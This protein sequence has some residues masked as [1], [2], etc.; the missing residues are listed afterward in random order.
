VDL[1]QLEVFCSV[2]KE[3][4]FSRAAE[5]L[6]LTQPTISIRIKEFEESIGTSLFNRLGREIEPTDAG[7]FLYEQALPLLAQRRQLSAKLTSFLNRVE[8]PVA[9]GTSSALG[10]HQLP[11]L[12][13]AFQVDHPGVRVKL[14]FFSNSER[15]LEE[16]RNGDIDLGV[17]V[18]TTVGDDVV[19]EPFSTEELVLITPATGDW[20]HRSRIP[21][22]ELKGLPLIVLD[23]GSATRTSLEQALSATETRLVDMNVVA[24]MGRTGAIKE[25]VK[26]GYGVAFVSRSAVISELEA[27]TLRTA[28]VPEIGPIRR[29]FDIVYGRRRQLSPTA[30]ACLEHLR[31]STPLTDSDIKQR[32][33]KPPQRKSTA[34]R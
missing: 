6:G 22:S 18:A 33:V 19:A 10:E 23:T 9:V 2:F 24:E 31:R 1:I 7:K 27:G 17:V 4:S 21:L 32:G 12:M 28:D 15:T 25:A 34:R 30:T 20:R 8:G 11:G 26:Q 13:M 29:S 14:R 5:V 3:R 16:L